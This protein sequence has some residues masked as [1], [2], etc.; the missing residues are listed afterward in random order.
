MA[1]FLEILWLIWFWSI[2]WIVIQHFLSKSKTIGDRNYQFK[3]EELL[4]Y[5]KIWEK[6]ISKIMLLDS[7]REVLK[8]YIDLS[9]QE[10]LSE[11]NIFIDLN[12][13]FNKGNFE[14]NQEEIA[15]IIFIYF[16][17]LWNDWNTCLDLMWKIYS[18]VYILD[19]KRKRL[20]KINWLDEIENFNKLNI[21]LWNLPHELSNNILKIL[22]DKEKELT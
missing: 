6:V 17:S 1:D 11:N 12:D 22:K 3:K 8:N 19:I 9:Y 10:S 7:H 18:T 21:N 15:S 2:L 5:R 16:N 4:F 13:T 20:D 14:K